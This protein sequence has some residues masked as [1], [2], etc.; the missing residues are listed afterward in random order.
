[1]TIETRKA[2]WSSYWAGG[3]L[4]SCVGSYDSNYS[5]AIGEF[6][7]EVFKHVGSGARVL[8]LATGNG[9]LPLMLWE[10]HGAGRDISVDAVDLATI[11]PSWHQDTVHAGIKFHPG[12]AME[13]LPFEGGSFDWVISQFGLE[14]A[15][16]PDSL[17]E[18]LRVAGADGVLAFVMHHAGSVLVSVGKVE[19]A[20]L[21][22]LLAPDGLIEA[23]QKVVP[24]LARTRGGE[25]SQGDPAALLAKSRYNSAMARLGEAIE[26][27]AVPDVLLQCRQWVHDLLIETNGANQEH[28]LRLLQGYQESLR[29]A[30]LRT[31]EMVQQALDAGQM[32]EVV[33]F[34]ANTR[35][36]SL[37]AC[38][39]LHQEEGILAWGLMVSPAAH[40]VNGSQ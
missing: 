11:K 34:L 35:P 31:G 4:H 27:S 22:L 16:R 36:D 24:W 10:L 14:Y 1:M 15:T 28:Q 32:K 40:P 25:A 37:I 26:R 9:A 8:D 21:E 20:N 3:T 13:Q 30:G 23:A 29:E 38:E 7:H 19:V 12:V 33:D 39:P 5:G 17:N 2:A 18:C 6:W